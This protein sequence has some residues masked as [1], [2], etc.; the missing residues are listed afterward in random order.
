MADA[1][2]GIVALVFTDIQ[3][4]TAIWERD[5]AQAEQAAC[6]ARP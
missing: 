4:S 5:R 6:A 2:I 3:G 1:S